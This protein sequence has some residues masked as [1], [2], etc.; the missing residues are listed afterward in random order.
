MSE[1]VKI[2]GRLGRMRVAST[3]PRLPEMR[4]AAGAAP[5]AEADQQSPVLQPGDVEALLE[6]EYRR[7][8]ADGIREAKE[9]FAAD[10]E[11]RLK[12]ERSRG[13]DVVGSIRSEL[14]KLVS[15]LEHDAFRFAL[16]VAEKI[17]KREIT[18]DEELVIR[19][20]QEGIRR[21]AGV[22]TLRLR[23][24]PRDEAVARNEKSS[25]QATSESLREIV[26][27]VDEKVERGGC[28]LETPSGTV[29][30]RIYT[31]LEQIEAALF[32]QVVS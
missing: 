25:L 27:E 5:A 12:E 26:I 9:S 10:M 17:V 18:F 8:R 24:N 1:V 3:S 23:V 2:V 20:I 15:R 29:D 19:Q 7:G 31:Q 30:A 16:A 6:A 4:S 13:E 32:G 14:D 11:V 28:I 22:E 21:V